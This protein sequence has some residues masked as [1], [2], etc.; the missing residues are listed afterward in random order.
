MS[1][2]LI[3]LKPLTPYFFGGE[4]T[5]GDGKINYYAHSNYLP[6]QT[7][8][9][10]MLRYELLHQNDL[11]GT[12]PMVK[13]WKSLIGENSFQRIEENFIDEFGA[14]E[15]ISPVFLSNHNQHYTT[16]AFDWAYCEVDNNT[17]TNNCSVKQ[18]KV[19]PI[20]VDFENS[21]NDFVLFDQQTTNIPIL[22]VNDRCYDPKYG[23][24]SLWVT[25]DGKTLRQW[26]Y[27]NPIEFD[28]TKGYENGLFIKHE[29]IGINRKLNKRR[30]EKGDFY[31]QVFYKLVEDFCLAFFVN[32][33]LPEGK[34]LESRII[35]MGGER[36]VFDMKVTEAGSE[37]FDTIFNEQTFKIGHSRKHKA[38]V[39]TSDCYSHDSIIE[40]CLFSI[41]ESVNFQNIITQ[42]NSVKNYTAFARGGV[43]KSGE[44]LT[45][46]KRGSIL[47]PQ[48]NKLEEIKLALTNNPFNKIGYN[49]FLMIN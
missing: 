13:D 10:G 27:E 37:S 29:Q 47:F 28:D 14:I 39:L 48:I 44:N 15:K 20:M 36:S 32:I 16:Q 26:N 7:T 6:Q 23:F 8:I 34:K 35:T 1:R 5:F 3:T 30:D 19:S 46:L 25:S 18:K 4:N 49:N 38:I 24:V 33:N 45:L 11:I 41:N 31:K 40:N 2:K 9:L 22:Y 43:T 17:K 12:D 42:Q 21:G